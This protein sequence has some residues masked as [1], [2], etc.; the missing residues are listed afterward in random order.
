MDLSDMAAPQIGDAIKFAELAYMLL[1]Y[2]VCQ[3]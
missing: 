3:I 2:G 1:D